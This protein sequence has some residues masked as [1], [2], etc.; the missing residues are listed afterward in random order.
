MRKHPG[1]PYSCLKI[2][3][4]K[5]EDCCGSNDDTSC[6]D[7][8][9]KTRVADSCFSDTALKWHLAI[10]TIRSP[11]ILISPNRF[12]LVEKSIQRPT[13][14]SRFRSSF[15][16]A[17]HH[18]SHRI[19]L[20]PPKTSCWLL[21]DYPSRKRYM[22]ISKQGFIYI[23]WMILLIFDHNGLIE[24]AVTIARVPCIVSSK[25]HIQRH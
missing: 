25:E 14:G 6:C 7:T 2:D 3:I 4:H 18:K 5:D 24:H 21:H 10:T 8:R 16:N 17:R 19:Y 13:A 9:Y 12:L 23:A 1:H 15:N 11:D 20:V 22:L